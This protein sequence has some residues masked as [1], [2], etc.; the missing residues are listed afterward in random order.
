MTQKKKMDEPPKRGS[1]WVDH[2]GRKLVV[3]KVDLEDP[4]GRQVQGEVTYTKM[5]AKDWATAGYSCS[6][7]IFKHIWFDKSP[8]M[9]PLDMRN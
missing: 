2:Q 3:K 7:A 1:E 8:L 6:L 4:Q 5:N 9:N